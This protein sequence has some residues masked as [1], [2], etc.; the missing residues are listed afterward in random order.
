[1]RETSWKNNLDAKWGWKSKQSG[2]KSNFQGEL[3]D[4]LHFYINLCF[5]AGLTPERLYKLYIAKNAENIRRKKH[6]Y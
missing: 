1:M 4:V 2:I 6:G 5:A 3:A